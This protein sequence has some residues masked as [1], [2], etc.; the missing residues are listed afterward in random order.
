MCACEGRWG[1]CR[2][3]KGRG[4]RRKDRSGRRKEKKEGGEEKQ[5]GVGGGRRGR[6]MEWEGGEGK[7]GGGERVRRRRTE[8]KG[9]WEE[10]VHQMTKEPHILVKNT[11]M[12][13]PEHR[14]PEEFL[15]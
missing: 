6:R 11:T 8:R 7:E 1:R 13:E 4:V 14:V 9:R 5:D 2:K 12:G 3:G 10:K 15:L